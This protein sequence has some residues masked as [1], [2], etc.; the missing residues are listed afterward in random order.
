MSQSRDS[1]PNGVT[2]VSLTLGGIAAAFAVASCCALPILLTSLGLGVAWL[3][4]I[5]VA[6]APYRI[7]LIVVATSCLLV[8]AVMLVRQQIAASKCGPNGVCSPRAMRITA[9]LGL[10]IGALLLWLG[11]RYA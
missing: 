8:G 6:A 3:G 2:A 10:V 7:P 1:R 9:L 4:G 11:Y 5:G